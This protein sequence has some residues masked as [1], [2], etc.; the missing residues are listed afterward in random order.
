MMQLRYLLFVSCLPIS[1]GWAQSLQGTFLPNYGK[2]V[3][4]FE[5]EA[6]RFNGTHFDYHM[7]GCTGD[8]S[9]G[10]T[11]T[12]QADTLK[13]HFE[14]NNAAA[15]VKAEPYAGE[16]NPARFYFKVLDASTHQALP[17]ATVVSKDFKHGASTNNAGEA[18]LAYA[19]VPNDSLE[20][21]ALGYGN[22]CIPASSLSSQSFTVALAKSNRIAAGTEYVYTIRK[23]RDKGFLLN[24]FPTLDYHRDVVYRRET[25][26]KAEKIWPEAE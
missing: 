6:L 24:R 19:A 16:A 11:Y 25:G 14:S 26:P 13:L 1:H 18:T 17:G 12:L 3:I 20:V 23:L 4:S 15:F 9:G 10:G 5:Y 21:S 2:E 8:Y 22:V 7:S